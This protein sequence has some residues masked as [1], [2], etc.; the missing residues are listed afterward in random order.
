MVTL[1][2]FGVCDAE[3]VGRFWRKSRAAAASPNAAAQAARRVDLGNDIDRLLRGQ[4]ADTRARRPGTTLSWKIPSDFEKAGEDCGR[5]QI[6]SASPTLFGSAT[7]V[8]RVGESSFQAGNGRAA[9][10]RRRSTHR[11]TRV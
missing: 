3:A 8:N 1:E 5:T 2:G 7:Y 11:P 9:V 4:C 10:P 6:L